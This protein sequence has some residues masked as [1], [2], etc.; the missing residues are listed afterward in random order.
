MPRRSASDSDWFAEMVQKRRSLSSPLVLVETEDP[1]RL[2]ELY[3][4]FI[5]REK[6]MTGKKEEEVRGWDVW[7]GFYTPVHVWAKECACGKR[8]TQPYDPAGS[9]TSKTLFC[10]KCRAEVELTETTI[11]RDTQGIPPFEVNLTGGELTDTRDER[12]AAVEQWLFKGRKVLVIHNILQADNFNQNVLNRWASNDVLMNEDSTVVLLIPDRSAVSPAVLHQAPLI[13]IPLSTPAERAMIVDYMAKKYELLVGLDERAAAVSATSG[14]NLNLT[15]AVIVETL[16]TTGSLDSGRIAQLRAE[17]LAK[18]L[19]VKIRSDLKGFETVGGYAKLKEYIRQHV[20]RP[21]QNRELAAKLGLDPARGFILYGPPGTGKTVVAEAIASELRYALVML[22]TEAV[23]SPYVGM[24]ERN[25]RSVIAV[26]ESISPGCLLMI[27]EVDKLG[28]RGQS[29]ELDGGTSRR[30][31][32]Q[33]LQWL[34]DRRRKTIVI[35][36]TNIAGLDPAFL[37][38]GRFDAVIPMLHPDEEARAEILKV[39]LNVVRRVPHNLAPDDFHR[40]A[41]ATTLWKGNELE[42]LVKEA[43]GVAFAEADREGR[44][45]PQVTAAHFADVLDQK[46]VFDREAAQRELATFVEQA[47]RVCKQREL[48]E[49][50]ETIGDKPDHPR[51]EADLTD[52]QDEKVR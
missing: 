45:K 51:R 8:V 39:H 9:A 24:S 5:V 36:T 49:T 52:L 17:S 19:D 13:Q 32:S 29:T 27:D 33:M 46:L 43:I 4:W 48:L 21:N 30:M 7:A 25:L 10:P 41:R 2:V 47:K 42:Q 14:L 38:E 6:S 35:G 23:M 18:N 34:G 37:R 22:D 44:K 16:D 15:E 31:F 40:L 12:F 28:G 50:L 1:R 26:C 11:D 20:I 3:T